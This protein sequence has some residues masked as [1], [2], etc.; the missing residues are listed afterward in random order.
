MCWLVGVPIAELYSSS[1]GRDILCRSRNGMGLMVQ[2]EKVFGA[3]Y[4]R[5][6]YA[7]NRLSLYD[8]RR[9]RRK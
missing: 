7:A 8:P 2:G 9:T 5:A 3:C 4:R 1:L 6:S